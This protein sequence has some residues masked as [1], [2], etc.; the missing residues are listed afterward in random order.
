MEIQEH[1]RFCIERFDHYYDSVNN[2]CALFLTVNTFIV[3]GLMAIHPTLQ[4]TFDCGLWINTGFT[5]IVFAGLLSV[6]L[7]LS[8]G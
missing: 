7:T 8:A 5:I 1:L 2:K 4:S 3:G 6:L